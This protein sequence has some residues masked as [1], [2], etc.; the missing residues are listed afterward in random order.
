MTLAIIV[1][2]QVQSKIVS[3]NLAINNFP[4]SSDDVIEYMFAFGVA[5]QNGTAFEK[6]SILGEPLSTVVLSTYASS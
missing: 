3:I 1:H 5:V 4:F 2:R 6:C